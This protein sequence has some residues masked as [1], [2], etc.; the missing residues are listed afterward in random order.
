MGQKYSIDRGTFNEIS[1]W[2]V[3]DAWGGVRLTRG[4]P[5]LKQGERGM[6]MTAKLPHK[7]FNIPTLRGSITVPDPESTDFQIDTAA[8]SEALKQAIGVDIDLRVVARGEE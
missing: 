7:L 2:L 3:F 1:F 4:E 8:A 6:A 5:D